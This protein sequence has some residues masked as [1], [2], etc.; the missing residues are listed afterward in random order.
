MKSFKKFLS[1]AASYDFDYSVSSG[2]SFFGNPENVKNAFAIVSKLDQE[3]QE[4][5]V[6]SYIFKNKL[7]GLNPIEKKNLL[8]MSIVLHR[9]FKK[10]P[11]ESEAGGIKSK[12]SKAEAEKVLKFDPSELSDTVSG[13]VVKLTPALVTHFEKDIEKK[14]IPEVQDVETQAKIDKDKETTTTK[15]SE[16]PQ[17]DDDE[18]QEDSD[19]EDQE[20]TSG[21]NPEETEEEFED[22]IPEQN[23]F[24]SVEEFSSAI[25]E[26]Q[27]EVNDY[28]EG[29]I[30]EAKEKG[31][32]PLANKLRS[33]QIQYA[34]N[35]ERRLK[36]TA[37]TANMDTYS[38]EYT[39]RTADTK[40][41]VED[42]KAQSASEIAKLKAEKA[43]LGSTASHY[44]KSA[45]EQL[46]KA[47]DTFNRVRESRTAKVLADKTNQFVDKAMSWSD[48][49]YK[50]TQGAVEGAVDRVIQNVQNKAK[51][52]VQPAPVPAQPA[53]EQ[54]T[55]VAPQ[56]AV[57]TYSRRRK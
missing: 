23:S 51:A 57:K 39:K 48:A 47:K 36:N 49:F 40:R 9:Y 54:Q 22:E 43:E 10:T 24:K 26:K 42:I 33:L 19:S 46:K 11:T 31:N 3:T 12:Y 5:I 20:D 15:A 18:E 45:K 25:K 28:Y 1:E 34:K 7:A 37:K 55:P 6:K 41:N 44:A 27:K 14:L 4:D 38:N 2:N 56:P 32:I 53:P 50:K 17:Q 21:E 30:K 16:A 13:Q 8:S 29:K 52:N 35:V